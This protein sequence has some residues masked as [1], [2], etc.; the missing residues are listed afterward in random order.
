MVKQGDII[1]INFNP[2]VG[3][4]QAGYRPAVVVGNDTFNKVSK[5]VFACPITNSIDNFPLH[6]KLDTRKVTKGI[7]LL[8]STR[9][10]ATFSREMN[11]TKILVSI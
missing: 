11:C 4:E 9:T 6:I 5:L 10:L 7:I 2:Q 8:N 1:K 3:H